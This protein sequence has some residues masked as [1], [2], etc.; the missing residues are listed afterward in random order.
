MRKEI[1][2][3][4]GGG[5]VVNGRPEAYCS[6]LFLIREDGDSNLYIFKGLLNAKVTSY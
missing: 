1:H 6:L 4:G 3:A 5:G 2:S